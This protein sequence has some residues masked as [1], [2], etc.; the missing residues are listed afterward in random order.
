MNAWESAI[1]DR[2]AGAG[3]IRRNDTPIPRGAGSLVVDSPEGRVRSAIRRTPGSIDNRVERVRFR[4][5]GVSP[6]APRP[7]RLASLAAHPPDRTSLHFVHN[8]TG[9]CPSGPTAPFK[10]KPRRRYARSAGSCVGLAVNSTSD[11][12]ETSS[13]RRS[14]VSSGSPTARPGSRGGPGAGSKPDRSRTLPVARRERR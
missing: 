12:G 5:R 3:H 6:G 11:V 8:G 2:E 1:P 14:K 10:K 13:T 9:L 4:R 7:L